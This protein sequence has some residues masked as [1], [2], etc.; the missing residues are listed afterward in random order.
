MKHQVQQFLK[1]LKV[2]RNCSEHTIT[3]YQK[4]IENFIQFLQSEGLVFE[5]FEYRDARNY[6]V[7]LYE[8]GLKRTTVSRHISAMRSFYNFLYQDTEH[9]NPFHQLVHPKQEK[10]LPQFFYEEEMKQLFDAIDTS[11]PFYTRDKLILELLYATGIRVAELATLKLEQIDQSLMMIKVRGK[12]NKTRLVPYGAFAQI[13]LTDYIALRTMRSPKHDYLLIN[14]RNAPLSERGIRYV[15]NQIV[16]QSATHMEIHPHKLRHTFATHLL[17][18]GADLRTVQDLLGHE[19][20]STTS[21]YTHVTKEH[22][23]QSYLNA[24]PR[25]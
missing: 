6:L 1:Y 18:N 13:A 5:Q 10:Y 16:K 12:G 2:D 11:K 3:A 17:N 23:K 7:Q 22:L 25:A 4:D 24:H 9:V 14:Q 21:R 8:L 19:N 15:L 20:L